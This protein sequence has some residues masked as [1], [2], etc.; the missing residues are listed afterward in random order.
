MSMQRDFG[1]RESLMSIPGMD[2]ALSGHG[3]RSGPIDTR[4][5]TFGFR[6]VTPDL[7]AA[8]SL[9]AAQVLGGRPVRLVYRTDSGA[10]WYTIGY[11][12]SIKHTLTA[13]NSGLT[14]HA[15]FS[16]TWRIRPY[17]TLRYSEASDIWTENPGDLWTEDATDLWGAGFVTAI[18]DTGGGV[19]TFNIDATGTAGANLPTL[20]DTGPVITINGPAGGAVGIQIVNY[21][22]TVIDTGGAITPGYFGMPQLLAG[23]SALLDCGAQ[24]FT[25]QGVPFRPVKRVFQ[26]GYLRIEAGKVNT[27]QVQPIGASPLFGG[28]INIDWYRKFA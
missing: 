28:A 22:T 12:P 27:I 16:V 14:P 1:R 26:P 11:T 25:I 9:L 15:D 7:D 5:E 13:K 8:Y 17:W 23:Q 4:Y 18:A 20:P 3:R 10:L 2:S 6:V 24:S 19:T 21:A